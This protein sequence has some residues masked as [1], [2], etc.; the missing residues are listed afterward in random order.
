MRRA[1]IGLLPLLAACAT[2]TSDPGDEFSTGSVMELYVTGREGERR[3]DAEYAG[4]ALH[5]A[6]DADR[7]RHERDLAYL[8]G[9]QA[10][11]VC[12][13]RELHLVGLPPGEGAGL[14]LVLEPVGGA[15]RATPFDVVRTPQGWRILYRP[16]L[17]TER[18]SLELSPQARATV[19]ARRLKV[20][21]EEFEPDRLEREVLRLRVLLQ[22]EIRAA[23]YAK[24]EG[25]ALPPFAPSPAALLRE[26]ESGSP[27]EVRT[28][29]V[30]ML[31]AAAQP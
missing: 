8:K 17:L 28:R 26:V 4:R 5:Y 18:E 22:H 13:R 7:V 25:V 30:T 20:H 9:V 2:T 14:Y 11:P 15:Y 31:D 24:S 1:L 3:R 29:V 19:A 21:W 16:S 12:A 6:S 23:E 27:D 10:G